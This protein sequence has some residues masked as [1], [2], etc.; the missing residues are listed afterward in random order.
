MVGSNNLYECG[1]CKKHVAAIKSISLGRVPKVLSI[2]LKRFRHEGAGAKITNHVKFQEK[3]VLD[4]YMNDDEVRGTPR[5]CR[6]LY[7]EEAG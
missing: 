3:L 7:Q 1:N 2:L 4:P 6:C 5:G